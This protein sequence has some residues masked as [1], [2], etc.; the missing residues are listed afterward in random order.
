MSVYL[1]SF[2]FLISISGIVYI[3]YVKIVQYID[4]VN[5]GTVC[6]WVIEGESG[7]LRH[8]RGNNHKSKAFKR[9]L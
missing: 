8:F 5:S 3:L 2:S 4:I 6:L 9:Q 7:S 1:F